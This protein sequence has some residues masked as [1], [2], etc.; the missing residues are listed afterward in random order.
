MLR[1]KTTRSIVSKLQ[2][3]RRPIF[4]QESHPCLHRNLPV[5]FLSALSFDAL[6]APQTE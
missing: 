2:E 5:E 4:I 3:D 1:S 6:L